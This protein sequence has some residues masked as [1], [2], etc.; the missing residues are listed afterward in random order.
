MTTTTHTCDRCG[1]PI[2]IDRT[3]LE[4]RCGPSLGETIELCHPCY[5]SLRAWLRQ[6]QGDAAWVA[7]QKTLARSGI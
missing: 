5:K 7:H 4:A 1:Q 2:L 6:P 3:L